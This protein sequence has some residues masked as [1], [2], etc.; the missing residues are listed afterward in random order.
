MQS[1]EGR[2]MRNAIARIMKVSGVALLALALV[3]LISA[4]GGSSSGSDD[5]AGHSDGGIVDSGDELVITM[6]TED[7]KFVPD[8]VTIKVGQTV[9]LRLDNHDAV[10]HDYTTDE[11]E[12]IVLGEDGAAHDDHEV[13]AAAVD[14]DDGD[15]VASHD[16]DDD[17]HDADDDND[18]D[19]DHDTDSDTVSDMDMDPGAQVSLQPLHIA[20]EGHEHGELVFEATEPGEYVFYCSVPGHVEAGMVGTIIIE[21]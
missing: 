15:A 20:A 10:L 21:E 13:V 14:G 19:D 5:A 3:A 7:F 9:R 8:S 2:E 6:R 17:D 18:A 12:F 16:D 11:A 1:N 4:C